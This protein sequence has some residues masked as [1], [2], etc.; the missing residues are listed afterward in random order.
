[1]AA[2]QSHRDALI[3]R[4]KHDHTDSSSGQAPPLPN[5]VDAFMSLIDTLHLGPLLSDDERRYLTCDATCEVWF[6]RDGRVIGSGRASRT[7]G[8]RLRRVL[9]HRDRCCVVPGCGATRG[10]HAH[11]IQ[12]PGPGLPPPS[13]GLPSRRH[14]HH[15]TRPAPRGH[16]RFRQTTD[17]GIAGP[18]PD[19]APA[20]GQTV[21]RADRRTRR[22]VVVPTLPTPTTAVN[23]LVCRQE[24]AVE[25]T[26][27]DPDGL[28]ERV[29]NDR[30]DQP[31]PRF[32]QRFGKPAG[33][34]AVHPAIGPAP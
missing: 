1:D 17:G 4:W 34:R 22:L 7:V 31:K 11:H 32:P 21:F 30:A 9:E 29:G 19:Y 3:A 26:V 13:P 18:P 14:H 8:R 25:M 15:R 12:H 2:L 28:H 6:E 16:R 33:F 10:L 5:T 27:L 23:Q 20:R 24:A